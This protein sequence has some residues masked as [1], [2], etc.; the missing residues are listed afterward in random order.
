MNM[1]LDF[2]MAFLD[3]SFIPL[4]V[5]KEKE[6]TWRDVLWF[7][8]QPFSGDGWMAIG[9]M[10]FFTGIAYHLLENMFSNAKQLPNSVLSSMAHL[11]TSDVI[12]HK[13]TV[14][15]KMWVFSLNVL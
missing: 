10:F 5:T 7:W 1:G 12:E 13:G 11:I 14:V 9:V 15:H 3:L 6:E 4:T 8:V 2:Q